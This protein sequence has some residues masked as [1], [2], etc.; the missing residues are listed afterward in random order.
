MAFWSKS[1]KGN[2]AFCIGLFLLLWS[3]ANGQVVISEILFNPPGSDA[4]N[5]YIELRGAPNQMLANGTYFVAVE[6]DANGNPGTIQHLFDLSS[7]QIG[8]NGFLVLLQKTN[9]YQ[10]NSNATLLVNTGKG[11]GFGSG[12]SSSIGHR[13]ESGQTEIENGSATYFLIQTPT[14]PVIG[15]DIDSNNDGVP[16]GSTYASWTILD[17]V[18]LLDDSGSGDIA[19]GA[20]NFR[21]NSAATASGVVVPI[22]FNADYVGRVGNTTGSAAADWVATS[23]LGGTVPSWTLG[24]GA[25][26]APSNLAL[27]PLNHIGGPNFGD[28][29]FAGVVAIQSGGSTD[30]LEGSG[31]DSYQLALNTAPS[32]TVTVQI[33]APSPVQVSID[34]G[35]TFG[36][37]R[38]VTVNSTAPRTVLVRVPADNIIGV[39]PRV[40]PIQHQITST[41]DAANYPMGSLMPLVN[42]NITERDIALLNELKVNPPGQDDPYEFVEIKGPPNALLTNVYFVVIEGNNGSN[43]GTVTAVINLSSSRI[44]SSTLLVILANGS[45]YFIPNGTTAFYD[46]HLNIPGGVLGNGSVSFLLLSS[47]VP[48]VEGTDLDGG[49]NGVLEGLPAGSLIM[50]AI[51]W[52]DGN[53]NDIVYGGAVLALP[54]GTPE[55]ATR[56]AWDTTPRSA[57]AWFFGEL[58]GPQGDT[59]DYSDKTV[60]E[61]FPTGKQ[62]T[63]GV[64]RNSAP[65]VRNLAA[66]SGAIGDPN[67]P[68]LNF[69]IVDAESPASDLS[70]A[71]TS[72]NSVVVPTGQLTLTPLSNGWYNLALNPIGVGYSLITVQVTDD[73]LTANYSFLYGAS[74]MGRFG[75]AFHI[76]GA[77]GST[78]IPIDSAWMLVGDDENQVLR[79]YDRHRSAYPVATFDITSFLGLTDIENG[80]PREVDIEA[81]TR[82][83]NRLFWMGA[84]SHAN[85]AEGRT[86]RSRI[87]RT[88]LTGA[89]T[90][91]ALNYIGRYDYL[92]LDLVNWDMNNGHGKGANYYGLAASTE[93][94]VDPKGTNGF[95]IEGLTMIAG[96]ADAAYVGLRAPI[97]SA[98]SRTYALLVPVLNFATLAGSTGPQGSAIFGPP[99]ELDLYGRGIR[100]I[101]GNAD[102]YMIVGGPPID[103]PT[104]Y[105]MDFRLYTWSGD[106][107]QNPQQRS[108]DLSGLNPEGIVELPVAPWTANSMVQLLSDSGRKVYY[109]DNIIAKHL[110]EPNLKKCRSDFVAL[111]NVVK[112][113]PIIVS[114]VISP[115]AVTIT[116]RALRGETYRVESSINCS[117]GSWSSFA[118]DVLATAP[119]MS[120]ADTRPRSTQLFYRVMVL[121]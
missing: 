22:I 109:G 20:I 63:P 45:P 70:L 88:D 89:G 31:T 6:G 52:S 8:G 93:E 46:G 90:N 48:L 40:L 26:T 119:Y 110:S 13:A 30:L 115:G 96:S 99:V 3:R 23:S 21:R 42:V 5:E 113:S 83:G 16:D 39:S 7:K 120:M 64:F 55:A 1:I 47:P 44:G 54:G 72:S 81:S 82:S 51:G 36:S 62:L 4:P 76:G 61:N 114:T 75:G 14:A 2:P 9:T 57:D 60:S 18:G 104:N 34:N 101:E 11:S 27:A 71:L 105:P 37:S 100:S 12:S 41:S 78:A 53:L 121:P 38:S 33:N 15:A 69:R 95:N 111:G 17:S 58:K 25:N 73:D 117:S 65:S 19:Y 49:D 66:L 28:S 24:S 35:A 107:A 106:P 77:D 10:V 56:F 85:I 29:P 84:H 112:P 102:G 116:W 103:V 67:N 86:N 79:L 108:A 91:V 92:K 68:T 50:D 97:I 98:T 87:F 118:P 94:G 74:E 43:P 32:G 59:L 80:K